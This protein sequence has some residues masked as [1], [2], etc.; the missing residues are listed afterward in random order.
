MHSSI[1]GK[2]KGRPQPESACDQPS[3]GGPKK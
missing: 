2:D 3:S 1:G